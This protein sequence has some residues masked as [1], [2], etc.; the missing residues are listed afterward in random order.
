MTS[1][2]SKSNSSIVNDI[3]D[4]ESYQSMEHK[5]HILN[6]PDTY[7]GSVEPSSIEDVWVCNSDDIFVQKDIEVSPGFYNIFNEILT[8]SSDQCLRTRE[9]IK[10]DNT[11]Q[12]TT[13][14]KITIDEETGIISVLNDGD[15]IPVV[16]HAEKK[17]MIPELIF[18]QLLTS[19]NYDKTKKK[20]WGGKNGYGSKVCLKI[21]TKIPTFGGKLVNIEDITSD[22]KLIGDDGFP[23]KVIDK[24]IGNDRLFEVSQIKGNPYIVNENHILCLRMQDHKVIFWNKTELAWTMLWLNKEEQ[25]IQSKKISSGIKPSVICP[26]CK[27]ELSSNL[28]RHYKRIHKD[29]SVP[30]QPRHGPTINAPDTPEV[31]EA[32]NKMKEF[33]KKIPDDNNL[34]ISVKD[35]LKLNKTMRLR[36]TGYVGDCVQW[37]YQNVDI[38]PYVLGLWLGDDFAIN[39]KDDP[40]I[41]EYLEDWGKNNDA[42]FKQTGQNPVAYNISSLSKCDIA[43]LKKQ[44]SKYNL[45]KNKHIPKEY[46]INSRDV[47]LKIL[48]GLIDS[49]G[50]VMQ[51]DSRVTIAQGTNHI[52]LAEDIIFLAKSLGFMCLGNIQK[53][54]WTYKGELKIGLAMLINIS[55]SGVEDIPTLVSRKNCMNPVKR[56]TASTGNLEIKE[57]EAGDYIGLAVD[58]NHRFVLEDFTVTHNCNIYSEMFEVETVDH[59]RGKKFKQVWKNNMS[60]PEKKAKVTE[61]K[62]K[63]YTKITFLPEYSRF[64]M[65]DGLK[66]DIINLIRKRAYDIAGC[67]PRDVGVYFNGVKLEIKDFPQYVEKYIGKQK[68]VKRVYE[69]PNEFWEIVACASPDGNHRQVSLVNGICTINGGKHVEYITNKI[70]KDLVAKVNGKTKTGGIKSNHVKNNLWVFINSLIV[71]PSFS[72][73]TKE[74]LTTPVANFGSK[75][76]LSDDFINK[77]AKTEIVDR[78]KLMKSFHDKSGLSKTDGKKTKSIRGIPKLDDANWAGTTKSNECTLILTEGDSAKALV[79]SGLSVVGRDKYGVFPLRGKLLNVR[80]ASDNQITGN[81][82]IQNIKKILGLQ[83]GTKTINDLRYGKVL[84]LTDQDKDGLHIK[85]LLM[86]MFACYW[87]PLLEEGFLITMYTPIV[88]VRKGNNVVKV[89]YNQND[90]EHWKDSNSLKGLTIKY[91]KGLGTSSKDEAKEYF[92]SLNIVDYNWCEDS[93]GALDLAFNKKKANKR[94]RWL[95]FYDQNNVINPLD[96]K[97]TYKNFVDKEL[98]H[99]SNYDNERSIP[100]F[101]DGNKTSQRKV[102]FVFFLKNL[103][104]EVKVAQA[105]S[106][107]SAESAYHHGEVSLEGTI[108]GLAQNYV[109]SNNINLLFPSGTFGGRLQGG[110]DCA[111]SRYI[112]TNLEK[113]TKL[114]YRKEDEPLLNFLVEEGD[115]IEPSWYLPVLPMILVNGG[116]GIG[117][118]F[119][120]HVPCFNPKDIITNL[121]LML[122]DKKIKNMAPWFR[123]FKGNVIQKKFNGVKKWYTE[124]KYNFKSSTILEITELPIGVWTDDYHKHLED[125]LIEKSDKDTKNKKKQCL[126]DY[127]KCNDHDDENVHLL[128]TFKKEV[129]SDLKEDPK[130]LKKI[131]KLEESKSCSLSNLHLYD[132]LGEIVKFNSPE[133]ILRSYYRIRLPFY[134]KRKDFTIKFLE[135]EIRYLLAKIRFVKGII[136]ETVHIS[137]RQNNEILVELRDKHQFPSDPSHD[138]LVISPIKKEVYKKAFEGEVKRYSYDIDNSDSDESDSSDDESKSDNEDSENESVIISESGN[139]ENPNGQS[140][141][142]T[143]DD[144]DDDKQDNS[145]EIKDVD[146]TRDV[147][148]ILSEDYG[149]LLTMH[150]WSLTQEKLNELEL[151]CN[152]KKQEIDYVKKVSPKEMWKNDLIELEK[153]L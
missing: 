25:R 116:H 37:E 48:A 93:K 59:R 49:N 84:I 135:R 20:T 72:S 136:E 55:G 67:S 47:R 140:P 130:K 103:I 4:N 94:K 147:K 32:F 80:E 117:T 115:S 131:L 53:T 65:P 68:D 106:Y 6:V 128:L 2:T 60:E 77:L 99:F 50:Y 46:L 107:V 124:G 64:G 66:G 138:E 89:F 57:V 81:S 13:A 139:P 79:I 43:Q 14:I 17:I 91:Y 75:C 88:K 109:G 12:I 104:K 145:L 90:Y 132:P 56:D 74:A 119:S 51:E 96:K 73:Q 151:S 5:E 40:E 126:I 18:G 152:K 7:I 146:E 71:N 69:K 83:Q 24:I 28:G 38:D 78:A 22:D 30:K 31:K 123:K 95:S 82:E 61:C 120:T 34:D 113:I 102:L 27:I 153:E 54:Q 137:K 143:D 100:S 70:C 111:Q 149:Y 11:V 129:L 10:K 134:K 36:L 76:E 41:L 62:G 9:Y 127:K 144:D 150:I 105:A 52:K 15:G 101:C 21:G 87:E 98:I 16:E 19:S 108:V 23:R 3:K 118:G 39:V 97:V 45:F 63:A 44:I 58:G 8:N 148:K 114:I 133:A 85:G 141:Y 142:S 110:K 29:L 35:F 33:A 42:K 92:K 26:E 125:L 121:K 86:N 112:F 1:K 122:D